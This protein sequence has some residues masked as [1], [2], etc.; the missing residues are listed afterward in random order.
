[1]LFLLSFHHSYHLSRLC[2]TDVNRVGR[3]DLRWAARAT[4]VGCMSYDI[5]ITPAGE[6]RLQI[7]VANK[8]TAIFLSPEDARSL[9]WE[10]AG[11]AEHVLFGGHAEEVDGLRA[12][13]LPAEGVAAML[14]GRKMKAVRYGLKRAYRDGN[15]RH[16]SRNALR[17]LH[18]YGLANYNGVTPRGAKVV[19]LLA[20]EQDAAPE[21]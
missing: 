8:H 12:K 3:L 11:K 16:V 21:K 20:G 17:T 18:N 14:R 4:I 1:M 5:S 10:L 6:V 19:R 13:R 15:T 7:K 2:A 9:G